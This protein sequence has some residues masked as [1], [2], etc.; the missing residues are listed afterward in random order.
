M[1]A[2]W[3]IIATVIALLL[4]GVIT[5]LVMR[6]DN[7]SADSQ[8]TAPNEKSSAEIIELEKKLSSLQESKDQVISSKLDLE[9][10]IKSRESQI[11]ELEAQLSKKETELKDLSSTILKLSAVPA[12]ARE[13]IVIDS[14]KKDVKKKTDEVE[15][16]EKEIL[17][18]KDEISSIEKELYSSSS[19]IDDLRIKNDLLEENSTKLEQSLHDIEK[20]LKKKT[21]EIDAKE[22]EIEELE[23]EIASTKKKLK[24][25]KNEVDNL[26]VELEKSNKKKKDLEKDLKAVESEYDELKIEDNVKSEAIEFV[27]A[28]LQAKDADDRDAKTIDE[29]VAKIE[30][31]IFDQYINLQKNYYKT[32]DYLDNWISNVRKITEHWANLQRKSWLKR[33]KVIA[34]IGEFSAGKTSIV[35]RILSQDDPNCPR[36]PVSSKAT[37][38]IP[39]YI[40]Y[41]E[42]FHSQFTNAK[43]DLKNLPPEMFLKVN[44]N[45]LAKVN[46][47]TIIHYFVMKYRNENLRGLSILDTPGFSSNDEQ[48][49][50]ITLKVIKE[51][52]ALFWVVDA[53]S[54]EVNRTSLKII[55]ENIQD[56]PLFIVINKSDTK[57]P[58]ELARLEGHIKQTMSRAEINVSGYVR[59]SQKA[60]LKDI[61]N[62]IESL[63]EVKTGLDIGEICLDLKRDLNR[64][65]DELK[66]YKGLTRELVRLI[67]NREDELDAYL[68]EI[69]NACKDISSIPQENS[70]W[71]HKNDY[72]MDE[73]GFYYLCDLCNGVSTSSIEINDCFEGY[74]DCITDLHKTSEGREKIKEQHNDTQKIHNQLMTAIK[75]LDPKLHQE[76]EEAVKYTLEE[77][78]KN[79]NNGS[80]NTSG[81]QNSN[82]S[83][84]SSYSGGFSSNT[85]NASSNADNTTVA[86]Q[87]LEKADWFYHSG[88]LEEAKFWYRA[89]AKHGNKAAKDMCKKLGIRY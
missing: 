3:V 1:E 85:T 18:L 76:I 40:S 74:K 56:T 75:A 46:V 31:I 84:S 45:I 70:R 13:S 5:W 51:A 6:K 59:F 49:K 50:E 7:A 67:E 57:S 27:N 10:Q 29:K 32:W 53:N 28:V 34:F 21:D 20:E 48:D 47:S 58:T 77:E 63:P 22:E 35:N 44:K 73:A 25:S 26:T 83:T 78:K 61:M 17:R 38:A 36:L 52:D 87:E 24:S 89:S 66:D 15:L 2:L 41:G 39:T 62:V 23:D 55:S 9:K 68:N 54:G 37:T 71:F 4:G 30:S 81:G 88:K 16:K 19:E 80:R 72:R 43:G 64:L 65:Q 60:P 12:D 79:A 82:S 86:Q 11:E 33:K 8:P 42:D 14:L 69:K